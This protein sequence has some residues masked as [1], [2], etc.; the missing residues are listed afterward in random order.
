MTEQLRKP[1]FLFDFFLPK[2]L[3]HTQNTSNKEISF[4]DD[5]FVW[6]TIFQLSVVTD[7]GDLKVFHMIVTGQLSTA[8]RARKL[9]LIVAHKMAPVVDLQVMALL[10]AW[11]MALLT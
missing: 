6:G 3:F 4:Q 10:M 1:S 8:L 11:H 9:D 7:Q 5:F 2:S